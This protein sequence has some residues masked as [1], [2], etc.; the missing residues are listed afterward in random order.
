MHASTLLI[1]APARIEE[2][3]LGV[4]ATNC[5]GVVVYDADDC[6]TQPAI[7]LADGVGL[8]EICHGKRQIDEALQCLAD[9]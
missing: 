9:A 4:T 8:D 7:R 6:P 1:Y 2:L 5:N 3:G